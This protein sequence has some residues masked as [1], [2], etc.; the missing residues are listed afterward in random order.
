MET[1][2]ELL[3]RQLSG[4][5]TEECRRI[6]R[7]VRVGTRCGDCDSLDGSAL[8]AE[9]VSVC[10]SRGPAGERGGPP[11]LGMGEEA[12]GSDPRGGAAAVG[13]GSVEE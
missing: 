3:Q 9:G 2:T 5:E 6:E 11:Q 4:G 13:A 12:D 1:D 10:D 7:A 8:D